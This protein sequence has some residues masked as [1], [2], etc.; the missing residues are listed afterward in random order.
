MANKEHNYVADQQNWEQ[1]VKTE[2]DSA[3]EWE[4]NWASL[5]NQE[6]KSLSIEDKIKALEEKVSEIPGTRLQSGNH[7]YGTGQPF[8]EV[9][10]K[11]HGRKKHD[12]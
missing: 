2:L 1:R 12:F 8:Q 10:R 7:T 6:G 4:R 5:Y 9:A 11:D 3:N